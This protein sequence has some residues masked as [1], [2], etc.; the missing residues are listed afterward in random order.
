MYPSYYQDARILW[1]NKDY[2]LSAHSN[3]IKL[4]GLQNSRITNK[5]IYLNMDTNCALNCCK[6]FNIILS[7]FLDNSNTCI[8]NTCMLMIMYR[9]LKVYFP[10]AKSAEFQY[11]TVPNLL[12]SIKPFGKILYMLRLV[13]FTNRI[14]VR[15]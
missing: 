7:I 9:Y 1:C 14:F 12:L 15:Y 5:Q 11:V 3:L 8:S 2:I 4:L 10:N 13:I 6:M